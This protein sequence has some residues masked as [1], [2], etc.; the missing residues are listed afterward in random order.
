MRGFLSFSNQ[1]GSRSPQHH[2]LAID[3]RH[4]QAASFNPTQAAAIRCHQHGP[5][6]EIAR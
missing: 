6:I 4:S 3:I 5:V 1:K 2:P